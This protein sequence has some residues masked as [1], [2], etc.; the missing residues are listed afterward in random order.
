MGR[1]DPL[2][3]LD[4]VWL[5]WVENFRFSVSWVGFGSTVPKVPYFM[6]IMSDKVE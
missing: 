6:E 2:V 4:W 5:G 3:G 1:V